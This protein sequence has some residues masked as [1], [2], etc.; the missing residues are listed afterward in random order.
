ML[1]IFWSQ[2]LATNTTSP[3][4]T[5]KNHTHTHTV[6]FRAKF[7]HFGNQKKGGDKSFLIFFESCFLQ[8]SIYFEENYQKSSH[9][10][11]S[12]SQSLAEIYTWLKQVAKNMKMMFLNYFFHI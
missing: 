9:F 8:N 11:I 6:F 10:Q 5:K 12:K 4:W 2:M 7:S 3:Q 1:N